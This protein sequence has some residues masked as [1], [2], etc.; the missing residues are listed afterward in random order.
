MKSHDTIISHSHYS[1]VSCSSTIGSYDTVRNALPVTIANRS[2]CVIRICEISAEM[3][4]CVYVCTYMEDHAFFDFN[5][6][7]RLLF[8]DLLFHSIVHLNRARHLTLLYSLV[9]YFLLRVRRTLLVHN[10]ERVHIMSTART[11][12]VRNTTCYYCVKRKC[13]Y[14]SAAAGRPAAA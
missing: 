5:W 4:L 13:L 2:S 6:R 10:S 1:L 12:S 11:T 7:Q 8:I 3:L 14:S 9:R